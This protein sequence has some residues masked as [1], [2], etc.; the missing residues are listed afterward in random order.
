MYKSSTNR[1][2]VFLCLE[3]STNMSTAYWNGWSGYIDAYNF[4]GYGLILYPGMYC[5]PG[6]SAKN[7]SSAAAGNY[8]YSVWPNE[9]E[10]YSDCKPFGSQSWAGESCSGTGP[11]TVWQFDEQNVC[12][13]TGGTWPNVDADRTNG[14]YTAIDYM[15]R[16]VSQP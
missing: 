13:Q 8:C 12:Q 7:C 3:S 16:L 4:D 9:P 10:Y 11:S 1:I 6:S 2:D 5:N 15:F 14:S